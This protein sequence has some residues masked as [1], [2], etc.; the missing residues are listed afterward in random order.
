MM[1]TIAALTLLVAYAAAESIELGAMPGLT[2][3]PCWKSFSG[4]LDTPTNRSLFH[5]YHESTAD[6]ANKPVVM[7][8]NGGP[9]CSSV[10]GMFTELGPYVVG[11]DQNVSLNPYAW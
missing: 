3:K 4:Y 10:S 6:S 1:K 7:W 8:L 9:G 2:T 11:A 5:F